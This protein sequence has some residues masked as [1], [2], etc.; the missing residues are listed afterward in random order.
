MLFIYSTL[1][2]T[3]TLKNTYIFLQIKVINCYS[4][5][6]HISALFEYNYLQVW[7]IKDDPPGPSHKAVIIFMHGVHR[8][9]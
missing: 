1:T 3:F 4:F 9:A 2:N 8:S 7:R 6:K 5:K